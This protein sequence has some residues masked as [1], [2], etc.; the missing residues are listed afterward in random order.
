VRKATKICFGVEVRISKA[1]DAAEILT[2]LVTT[3]H[4]MLIANLD[5]GGL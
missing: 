3:L 1:V 5:V 4:H 2:D